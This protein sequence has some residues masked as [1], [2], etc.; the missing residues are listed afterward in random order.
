[1]KIK[2][3]Q[4]NDVIILMPKGD[5]NID[6]SPR[7]LEAFEELY[8]KGQRKLV[9]DFQDVNYIDSFGLGTL[10]QIQQKLSQNKGHLAFANMAE[11]I[12]YVFEISK[13][14]LMLSIFNE[15]NDAVASLK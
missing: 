9:L 6:S 10:I 7:L 1:M 3:S 15:Q 2:Q 14:N 8:S 4:N 12:K 11:K 5:I 13:I